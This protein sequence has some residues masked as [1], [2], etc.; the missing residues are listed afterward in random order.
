MGSATVPGAIDV[1]EAYGVAWNVP[2]ADACGALFTDDGVREWMVKPLAPT[3][4]ARYE[5]RASVIEGIRG[6]VTALPDIRVDMLNLWEVPGGGV[7]E[8]RGRSTSPGPPS[9]ACATAVSWK[10]GCTST[11]G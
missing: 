6:F 8:W 1:I 7:L 10:S 9:T 5:G 3:I 2:D 4:P 11:P